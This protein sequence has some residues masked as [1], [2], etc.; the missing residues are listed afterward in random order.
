MNNEN[1][2][3]KVNGLN[4]IQVQYGNNKLQFLIDTGA[5]VSIMFSKILKQYG[6]INKQDIVKINGINGH[7]YS[8]GSTELNLKIQSHFINHKFLVMNHID[9]NFQGILGTDFLIKYKASI[10]YENFSMSLNIDNEYC[11]VELESAYDYY[12]TIPPRCETIKYFNCEYDNDCVLLSE[13]LSEGVYIAGSI[14]K[15]ENKQIP[16]K[17]LNVNDKEVKI[18]NFRPTIQHINDFNVYTFSTAT[19]SVERVDRVLDLIKIDNSSSKEHKSIQKICAKYA[20]V[21][22]L[23][24]DKLSATNVMKQ[25]I[26]LTK[27]ASPVY[28]KPYR[29]PHIQKDE[30][31]R[32]I[33]EMLKDDIIEE[34]RS[35]W[36]SPVLIV[37][38]KSG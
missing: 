4:T 11:V 30:I 33:K 37:P 23:E 20:D 19:K 22:Y 36:S 17:I 18:R 25:S 31:D 14:L 10:N 38:K 28:I 26:T 1:K 2:I 3:F 32:Q 29:L 12:T 5:S 6:F 9:D 21:F 27:N 16:V 24:G 13:N 7:T 8:I 35:P 15:P 34:A